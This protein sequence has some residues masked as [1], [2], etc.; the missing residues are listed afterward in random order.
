M[1][2]LPNKLRRVISHITYLPNK[3]GRVTSHNALSSQQTTLSHNTV[4]TQQITP[5][6]MTQAVYTESHHII[7]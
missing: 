3:V 7:H 6:H 1:H 4:P 2:Y 5:S